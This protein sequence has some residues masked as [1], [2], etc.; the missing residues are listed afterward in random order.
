MDDYLF[1][2]NLVSSNRILY[3][4]S[5]FAKS[6]LIH[7]Q[8]VGTLQAKKEHTSGREGLSSYLFFLIESGSGTLS[9]EGRDLEL[10][11]GDCIFLDC[12]KKYS[13]TTSSKL[14]KLKWV[15]F[16]GTNMDSIYR[17]YCE[18]GGKIVFHPK[19]LSPYIEI[20][21]NL[22]NIA[23]SSDY[24]RDMKIYEMLTK[25]L[26][27]LMEESWHPEERLAISSKKKS[28]QQIKAYIDTSY[29]KKISLDELSSMFFINKFY[30]TRVFKEQYGISISNYIL[31]RRITKAK[32]LLRF[33]DTSLE[34]IGNE[35]GI[36]DANYFSRVFKKIEG[37]TPSAYR[38][39]WKQK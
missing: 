22:Y 39:E 18:R 5:Q 20:I 27:L 4:P 28:L 21:N 23:S 30:L 12:E 31:E 7:L 11:A 6:T 37:I 16:Q 14:W 26:T 19:N 9:Y 34:D 29:T 3:T 17:K 35:V 13:H 25:L 1:H 15:H 32:H 36:V 38:N 24:L 33:S 2:G 8:E 10:R